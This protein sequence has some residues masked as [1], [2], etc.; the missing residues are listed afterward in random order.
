MPKGL[1][2]LMTHGEFLD[3]VRFISELGKPGPY[4]IRTVPAIQRW[5]V[6]QEV[7]TE[8]AATVPDAAK[9]KQGVL[10]AADDAWKPAYGKVSGELPLAEIVPANSSAGSPVVLY[11]F[12]EI[13]VTEAGE[14]ELVVSGPPKS[15]VWL[16]ATSL[17]EAGQ[18]KTRVEAGQHKIILRVSVEPT[19]AA[20]VKVEFAKPAG[21][22][23]EFS[24]V[25]G[26]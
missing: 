16:D 19:S 22:T 14:L 11:L 12:G 7:P 17:G 5:R 23:V 21:S 15:N 1:P 8:L 3:V 2:N 10:D 13:D 24:V 6:M 9:F 18:L 25:G 26:R 4:A 20:T